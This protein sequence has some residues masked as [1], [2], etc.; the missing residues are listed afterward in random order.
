M[1]FA[2]VL[3]AGVGVEV[4]ANLVGSRQRELRSVNG[5]DGHAVPET[6]RI[7]WPMPQSKAN[8]AAENAFKYLPVELLASP[9]DGGSTGL[10]GVVPG[11]ILP[12]PL[13]KQP[14]LD[15][16]HFCVPRDD[17]KD[18]DHQPLEGQLAFAIEMLWILFGIRAN[19]AGKEGK[20]IL[21][22]SGGLA[23]KFHA[24]PVP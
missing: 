22:K 21:K 23:R 4:S 6:L 11:A 12:G 13:E 1:P 3:Q 19:A 14:A 2:H 20:N 7:G 17:V 10:P 8:N 15:V 5:E 16:Y 18:E 9:G 24:R